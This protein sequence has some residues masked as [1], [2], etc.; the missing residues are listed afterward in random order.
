M[1]NESFKFHQDY[2]HLNAVV[3]SSWPGDHGYAYMLGFGQAVEVLLSA[4]K[5]EMYVDPDTGEA[6][7]VYV[8]ALVYPISFCARHFVELF[9]KRQLT[10]VSALRNEQLAPVE[11]TAL[12]AHDL[13]D[14]WSKLKARI[15]MDSRLKAVGEPLEPYLRDIADLDENG[16]TF[17]YEE[18]TDGVRHLQNL[19]HINLHALG[20]RLKELINH[21]E[22][23]ESAM[24]ALALEY[25]Q[26][27]VVRE[28]SR[29]EIFRIASQLPPFDTWKSGALDE[30]KTR[31]MQ[32]FN[33]SSNTFG[34]A[35]NLIK[36]HRG[37]ASL[38]GKE[39][40]LPE[41]PPTVFARLKAIAGG[42]SDHRTVTDAEWVA[43]EAVLEVGRLDGYCEQYEGLVERYSRADRADLFDPAHIARCALAPNNRLK[44]GLRKLGQRTLLAAFDEQFP[45]SASSP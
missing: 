34:L 15:Q 4:S 16:E 9:L 37:F 32:E 3:G 12:R 44:Q 14:L 30:T 26:G 23:F 20:Q 43:L 13:L 45:E 38:I 5:H 27:S 28:L 36:T 33:I 11:R 2:P 21:T 10:A 39:L 31:L 42:E 8:D 17:R 25:E 29:D 22:N 1:N 24:E 40:A 7:A 18:S 35:L 6:R 41:L 19:T